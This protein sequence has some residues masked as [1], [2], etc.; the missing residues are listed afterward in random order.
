MSAAALKIMFEAG[1][2][3]EQILAIAAAYEQHYSGGIPVESA[4]D[5]RREWDRERK[6]AKASTQKHGAHSEINS[7]GI[8]VENR[9]EIPVENSDASAKE[10][11]PTP[12][13]RKLLNTPVSLT[14]D[15]PKGTTD[16][17]STSRG[18]RLSE[19]W[20]PAQREIDL[21]FSLGMSREELNHAEIEFRNYWI[22]IPG[23]KG[24]KLDWD[25]TFNNRVRDRV[26]FLAQRRPTGTSDPRRANTESR[27][28]AWSEVIA[29]RVADVCPAGDDFGGCADGASGVGGSLRLAHS[30]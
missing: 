7:G 15:I 19:N 16:A 29:E 9:V 23:A 22:A 10:F 24:R 2:K 21:A 20:K 1:L 6:R 17:K 3:P 30:R 26:A 4:A 13:L 18:A 8:P 11:P 27:R 25:A 28:S 14:T 12:P 5:R